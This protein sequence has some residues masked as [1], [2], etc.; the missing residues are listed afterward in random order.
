VHLTPYEMISFT[1]PSLSMLST[2]FLSLY[3]PLADVSLY[4]RVVTHN[5]SSPLAD[6][7]NSLSLLYSYYYNATSM[8]VHASKDDN[9]NT[10]GDQ[11]VA[12]MQTHPLFFS[13]DT[14]ANLS[15]QTSFQNMTTTTITTTTNVVIPRSM[16]DIND[17][18][19]PATASVVL[20][21]LCPLVMFALII[22][23][24]SSFTSA[25]HTTKKTRSQA[26]SNAS[27]FAMAIVFRQF[28]TGA[29]FS[30][31]RALSLLFVLCASLLVIYFEHAADDEKATPAATTTGDDKRT[32]A[33]ANE[34]TASFMEP[35]DPQE[36]VYRRPSHANPA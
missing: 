11:L 10:L 26:R 23:F 21:M 17:P 30:P 7:T 22:V 36:V 8:A 27:A 15:A 13:P 29:S 4:T 34:T 31:P 18:N 33:R 20:T 28:F 1:L 32:V 16:W 12:Y 24:L 25:Q 14:T 3:L 35:I 9:N 19:H 2:S 6:Y 5:T